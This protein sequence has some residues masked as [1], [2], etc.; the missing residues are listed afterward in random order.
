MAHPLRASRAPSRGHTRRPGKAGASGVAGSSA[1]QVQRRLL[2]GLLLGA[3]LAG[4]GFA[5]RR[6]PELHF[7]TIGLLGFKADS[8]LAAELKRQ[9]ARTPVK[10]LE[11]ANRAE[12]VLEASEDSR[13]RRVVASTSAG[14][15]REWQLQLRLDYLL[16]TPAGEILLP[17]TELRLTR[18]MNYTESAALAK[19]QEEDRKSTRLNSSHEFVS[20]MPSSA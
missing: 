7:S 14:Q 17:F 1:A 10:L 4:C 19:E 8:P 3:P 11:D 16:R 5:P 13:R 6:E 15:V 18:D 20:R 2:L 9:I 12:V